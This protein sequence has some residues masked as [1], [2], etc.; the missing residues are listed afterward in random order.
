MAALRRAFRCRLP[1]EKSRQARPNV[2]R[3]SGRRVGYPAPS[4]L[5]ERRSQSLPWVQSL[6]SVWQGVT[7]PG[8]V[9]E[10]RPRVHWPAFQAHR[11]PADRYTQQALPPVWG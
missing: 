7:R 8:W 4:I 3:Q 11:L 2:R 9:V 6:V 5:L 1:A 10:P